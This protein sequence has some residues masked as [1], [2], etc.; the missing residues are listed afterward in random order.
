MLK[1]NGQWLD[2]AQQD[3]LVAY[4]KFNQELSILSDSQK[5]AFFEGFMSEIDPETMREFKEAMQE[6]LPFFNGLG[7]A[8]GDVV[9]GLMK[10]T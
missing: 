7:K 10:M 6:A 8:A 1:R 5:L 9:D 2:E 3:Q 4:R